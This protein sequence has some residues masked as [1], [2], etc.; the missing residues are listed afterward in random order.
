MSASDVYSK[1]RFCSSGFTSGFAP[2]SVRIALPNSFHGGLPPVFTWQVWHRNVLPFGTCE[3]KEVSADAAVAPRP[4]ADI[5]NAWV[6]FMGSRV[7]S[8]PS[9][10]ERQSE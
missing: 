10:V 9:A 1:P 2:P 8:D 4:T 7:A 6:S 5:T 3:G